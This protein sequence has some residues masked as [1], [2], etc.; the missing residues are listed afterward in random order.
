MRAT[1]TELGSY[2]ERLFAV[3]REAKDCDAAAKQL[4]VLVPVFQELGPRMMKVK[5]RL[6][7]LPAADREHIMQESEALMDGMKKRFADADA[8]AQKGKDCEKSSATFAAVAP[9]VMFVKKH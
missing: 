2:T 3:M 8:V 9:K 1:M 7:A 4:E 6:M 5:E